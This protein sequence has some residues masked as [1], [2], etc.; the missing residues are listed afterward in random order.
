MKHLMLIGPPGCGRVAYARSLVKEPGAFK[1]IKA[2]ETDLF[3]IHRM[4]GLDMEPM[5]IPFRAPHHTVS[6]AAMSGTLRNGYVVYPG[7]LSLAHGGILLLDEAA[8]FRM[9]VLERVLESMRTGEVELNGP[10]GTR[11][12]LPTQFRLV[13]ST[14]M[15]PCGHYGGAKKC[16]CTE[17]Q[18]SRY[19]KRLQGFT[20]HCQVIEESEIRAKVS[21]LGGM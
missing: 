18:R 3:R 13:I 10:R 9:S 5:S 19:M 8:E 1:H 4:A 2:C 21:E 20:K 15:C 14:N 16:H 12:I 17:G 6:D 7:E 11:V